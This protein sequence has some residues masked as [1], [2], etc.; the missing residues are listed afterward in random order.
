[1]YTVEVNIVRSSRSTADTWHNFDVVEAVITFAPF[2]QSLHMIFMTT[3]VQKL[4]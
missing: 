4:K 2:P 3:A 1:M